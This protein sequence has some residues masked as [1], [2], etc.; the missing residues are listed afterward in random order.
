MKKISLLLSPLLLSAATISIE[1]S[2]ELDLTVYNNGV[3]FVSEK[4]IGEITSSGK[5]ILKY[6]N[7][8]SSIISSSISSKFSKPV[9]L[10][11]QNYRYDTFS[12]IYQKSI[13]EEIL[14][15]E[16]DEF[17]KGLLVSLSPLLVKNEQN[18]VIS[19]KDLTELKIIKIPFDLA[20]TPSLFWNIDVEKGPLKIDLNYLTRGLSWDSNY[21]LSKNEGKVD[22]QGWI[23]IKNNSG[24]TFS[25][26]S[27]ACVAGEVNLNHQP[28]LMK[29]MRANESYMDAGA[30]V[31]SE[32]SF[33][34]YHLYKIPFKE[35][36]KD[37]EEKQINFLSKT[38]LKYEE[39]G[40]ADLQTDLYKFQ[41]RE[42]PVFNYFKIE[43][44]EK[45]SLGL[46][47]PKGTMRVFD[48]DKEGK[49]RFIGED[50]LNYVQKDEE[51]T[52]K[53]GILFDIKATEEI[54]SFKE[55]RSELIMSSLLK[56]K[57]T[58][59]EDKVIKLKRY[60]PENAKISDN[61]K[62]EC[63]KKVK[64]DSSIDY[65]VKIKKESYYNLK[66]NIEIQRF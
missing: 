6:D 65:I 61:C 18:E 12:S 42:V 37:K 58:G 3:G 19:L 43:N 30:P 50:N 49:S 46:P 23:T 47:I 27:L 41:K 1:K 2:N 28:M 62:E 24:I 48:K 56:I 51:I 52:L 31:V 20:I 25:D 16:K 22:L 15:K 36:I 44:T 64:N 63:S 38:G 17:K 13:G 34:G 8:P 59:N 57:N 33:G 26:A 35:T 21:I 7:V 66:T 39:Y 14:Y 4:R 29:S 40:Y 5:N 32:E 10:Y 54:I 55:N 11:S 45:N 9:T 53:T 60:I